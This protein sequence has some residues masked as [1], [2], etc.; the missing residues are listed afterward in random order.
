[1]PIFPTLIF[2]RAAD[3]GQHRASKSNP[4]NHCPGAPFV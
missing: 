4:K 1:Y 3:A 2:S